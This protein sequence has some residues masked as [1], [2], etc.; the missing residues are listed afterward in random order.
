MPNIPDGIVTAGAG[1]GGVLRPV[2]M[3][4][5]YLAHRPASPSLHRSV[6]QTS[7][8]TSVCAHRDPI[9]KGG[10]TSEATIDGMLMENLCW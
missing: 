1:A 3:D 9:E 8:R 2:K 5:V 6:L 10:L 7:M 4:R